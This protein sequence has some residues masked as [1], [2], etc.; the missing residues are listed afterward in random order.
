MRVLAAIVLL[1]VLGSEPVHAAPDTAL[2]VAIVS[3]TVFYLP[4]W[5]AD[6]KG[7]IAAQASPARI[8]VYDNAE[9]ITGDLRAGMIDIAIA[10]PESV[11]LDAARGGSLRVIAGNAER[12]PHFIIARPHIAGVEQLRGARIGVLSLQEGTTVLVRRLAESA[13]LRPD[14]YRVLAVGGAPTRWRLLQRGEIDVGLQPFPLSYE[15]EAA[16]F[17]NLGPISAYVPD[18]LFTTVNA[19]GGWASRNAAGVA[20]FLRALRLGLRDMRLDPAAAAGIASEELQTRREFAERAISDTANLRILS[21]DLSISP[22]AFTATVEM[23]RSVGAL[24]P[25][26]RIDRATVIDDRYLRLAQ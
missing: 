24:A 15:A 3:R 5:I 20:G 13:G 9:R 17:R 26:A 2:R 23:L 22:R 12:L 1:A 19:D 4:L 6:R 21:Q 8:T 11:I 10:P 16:G 18:Y 25:D 14:E 7:Y